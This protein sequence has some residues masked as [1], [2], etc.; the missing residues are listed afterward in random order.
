MGPTPILTFDRGTLI[1][2]PPPRSKS[3]IYFATWDDRIEKFRIPAIKY[4]C[5][6]ETLEADDTDFIDEAKKF[7]PLELVPS[8]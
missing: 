4:R 5:L 8:L 3:W 1:L 6:V 2:H 7:Y